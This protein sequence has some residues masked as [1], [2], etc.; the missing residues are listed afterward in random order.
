MRSAIASRAVSMRTGT[1][2]PAPRSRRHT[3]RP[4]MSGMPTSST[5]AS[6]H[7]GRH[8]GERLLAALGHLHLVAAER[9]RAAQRVAHG[10]VVIDY[11]DSHRPHSAAA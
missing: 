7:A 5:T 11:E 8:L 9:Q 1:R 4:S 10:A 6:G 2:L 3:S